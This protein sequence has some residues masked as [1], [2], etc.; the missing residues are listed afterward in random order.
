MESWSA[1]VF[2][3]GAGVP[4]YILEHEGK[5]VCYNAETLEKYQPSGKVC[6]TGCAV[7]VQKVD[8]LY[9]PLLHQ[10]ELEGKK[11]KV[12]NRFNCKG[13]D[14]LSE[15][16]ALDRKLIQLVNEQQK[17]LQG[18]ERK[19]A[20]LETSLGYLVKRVYAIY[21]VD[22]PKTLFYEG[23]ECPIIPYSEYEKYKT[24]NKINKENV[25]LEPLFQPFAGSHRRN[26]RLIT[27]PLKDGSIVFCVV[28][29]EEGGKISPPEE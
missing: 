10:L 28:K 11:L 1:K 19:V 16:S 25:T 9:L 6:E 12:P 21:P 23:K 15:Q 4:V 13:E 8:T 14:K 27:C 7:P 20:D 3:D 2:R 24:E 26:N 29:I 5:K 22:C 18:L 17:K